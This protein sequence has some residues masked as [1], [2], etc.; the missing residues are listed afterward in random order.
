MNHKN[1]RDR[2]QEKQ[3]F[4]L[5]FC[6]EYIEVFNEKDQQDWWACQ[7]VFDA[8]EHRRTDLKIIGHKGIYFL[9]TFFKEDQSKEC[10]QDAQT[11]DKKNNSK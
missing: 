9:R 5:K 7:H 6:F 3:D 4:G 2:Q 1:K 8:K 11:K 10:I